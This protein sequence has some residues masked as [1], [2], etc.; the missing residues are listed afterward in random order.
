MASA[1][2]MAT[3]TANLKAWTEFPKCWCSFHLTGC[4]FAHS[5]EKGHVDAHGG[6]M[7]LDVR[8]KS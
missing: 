2:T 6:R 7:S 3:L 5:M 1:I 8:Q 4:G